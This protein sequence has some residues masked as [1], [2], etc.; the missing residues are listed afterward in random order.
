MSNRTTARAIISVAVLAGVLTLATACGTA[1]TPKPNPTIPAVQGLPIQAPV[2]A[3]TA[4]VAPTVAPAA[5]TVA[6]LAPT[7]APAAPT[8]ATAPTKRATTGG[9]PA[10][11][12]NHAGRTS[13]MCLGCHGTAGIKPI[14]AS[15]AGRTADMCLSCHK[16]S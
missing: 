3:T 16:L 6:P 13:D 11:L 4:P 2:Q 14:P 12:A 15:H 1:A 7:V 10:L 8:A 9:A 5:P